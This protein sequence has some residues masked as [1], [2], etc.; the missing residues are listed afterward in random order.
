MCQQDK[1]QF[2]QYLSNG[3]LGQ[4]GQSI[5]Q[6][7]EGGIVS[8]KL[9]L[10]DDQLDRLTKR[11]A[12]I[13]AALETAIKEKGPNNLH[14]LVLKCVC[15]HATNLTFSGKGVTATPAGNAPKAAPMKDEPDTKTISFTADELTQVRFA[16]RQALTQYAEFSGPAVSAQ[17]RNGL[18]EKRI[19]CEAAFTKV[20]RP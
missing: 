9:K 6:A 14:N 13:E 1:Q 15:G 17:V 7:I 11:V 5:S 2:N 16:L 19:A 12:A 3:H 20:V 4:M 8:A 10:H 18:A